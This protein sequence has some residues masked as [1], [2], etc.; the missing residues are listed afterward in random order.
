MLPLEAELLHVAHG[1]SES[2]A[3]LEV[4]GAF[5]ISPSAVLSGANPR[6][7]DSLVNPGDSHLVAELFF[8]L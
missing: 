6:G 3:M 8:S 5:S 4:E 1:L 2:V 7:V